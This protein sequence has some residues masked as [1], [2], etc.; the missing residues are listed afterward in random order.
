V[1][2]VAFEKAVRRKPVARRG[3]GVMQIEWSERGVWKFAEVVEARGEG[4]GAL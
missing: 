1:W 4:G 2:G 3:A